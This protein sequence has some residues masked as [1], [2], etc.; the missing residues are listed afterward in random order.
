M[1]RPSVSQLLFGT[2]EAGAAPL[3]LDCGSLRLALRGTRLLQLH[4]A[5][6]EQA[7][8]PEVWHGIDFLYRDPDWGTPEP[9]VD[10][11]EHS[12]TVNGFQVRIEGRIPV[13]PAIDIRIEIDGDASGR[14]RYAATAVPRGDIDT[15]RIG[16]CL[17]HPMSAAGR[18]IEIEHADGRFSQSTFPV[19][20]APWPPFMLIRAIRHQYAADAWAGCRF[21]GDVFEFEDQRNNADAS[22]KTYSRCNLMPRPYRLS[23]GKPIRQAV[24]LWLEPRGPAFVATPVK[25]LSVHVSEL[26]HPLPRIG[27]AIAPA[28][29]HASEAVRRAL[30]S[31]SPALLH[32]A[33]ASPGEGVDWAGIAARLEEAGARLRLDV[34]GL[35][36]ARA[37][38]DLAALAIAI[39]AAGITPESVAVFPGPQPVIDAARRA[40]PNVSIGSGTPHFFTQLNRIENMG[41]PDFVSFTTASVVHGAADDTV[42]AGLRSLPSMID[43]IRARRPGAR[44]QMGPSGIAARRSPLGR[45]PASDGSRR[46]ALARR[47]PRNRALFGAAW[48]LGYLA[49]LVATDID[50]LTLMSLTGDAGISREPDPASGFPGLHPAFFV[51]KE[52]AGATQARR[53]SVSHPDRIAA[54][55][56]ERGGR[57]ELWI[58]NLESVP[59]C[60]SFNGWNAVDTMVLDLHGW[61]L[62]A[63][64]TQD[65]PWRTCSNDATRCSIELEAYAVARL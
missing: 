9:V 16:L 60:V 45:Q 55:A 19:L 59:V 7:D 39:G 8:D 30:R 50:A 18:P 65:Q 46:L 37:E 63:S 24:E 51:L 57:C 38:T 54:L 35:D 53:V 10:R 32:L 26:Q 4:A 29:A 48:V 17:M 43:T 58:A 31:L 25:P 62:Y 3:S 1:T 12:A 21:E 11:M 36:A 33:L 28:D 52:L 15:N 44:V 13:E 64:G 5:G 23:A 27:I 14:L 41:E 40:F 2:D 49:Q 6:D 42:M 20:I 47:D 34:E 22:F 61:R 56:L